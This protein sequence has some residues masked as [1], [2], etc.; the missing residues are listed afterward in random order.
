MPFSHPASRLSH[1][2]RARV[3]GSLARALGAG[4]PADRALLAVQDV[5]GN[6][7]GRQLAECA[8]SVKRGSALA[9]VLIRA[10][11]VTGTDAALLEGGEKAGAL[12]R[13][14]AGMANRYE[15]LHRHAARLRARLA[16]PL[17]VGAIGVL[18]L[19]L[20][21]LVRGDITPL[22]YLWQT[23]TAAAI[24]AVLLIAAS[25]GLRAVTRGAVPAWSTSAPLLGDW[26]GSQ[27]RVA[28]LEQLHALLDAGVDAREATRLGRRHA[29]GGL[30]RGWLT[31]LERRLAAGDTLADAMLDCGLLREG[32]EHA[33]VSTGE[34]AGRT[35]ELLGRVTDHA[36]Q[37]LDDRVET[38][39]EWL[40]RAVYVLVV[41]LL[42][43]GFVLG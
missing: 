20:P 18:V 6:A 32:E 2:D 19:P 40:P 23:L 14:L 3:L 13:V 38:I 28:E 37:V 5:A 29:V 27:A 9:R 39:A 15:H 8:A 21:A 4:L 22:G 1:A 34:A 12:D 24:C 17:A 10:R 35:E 11:L 36:R 31:R 30:S 16:M 7:L 42:A 26:I 33:L 41:A 43:G 25:R